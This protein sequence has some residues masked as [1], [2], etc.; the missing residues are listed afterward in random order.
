[1]NDL[2]APFD[3]KPTYTIYDGWGDV[4]YVN[5]VPIRQ[6]EYFSAI[7]RINDRVDTMVS[8]SRWRKNT[9]ETL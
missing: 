2:F 4:L 9:C 6:V 1:M 3:Q 7:F 8:S 5:A